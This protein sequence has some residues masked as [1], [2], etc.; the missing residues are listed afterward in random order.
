MK[1]EEVKKMSEKEME[2]K[3][4]ELQLELIKVKTSKT[5]GKSKQI[6]KMI[7]RIN[8]FKRSLQGGNSQK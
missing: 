3:L 7:A 1:F 4:E 2:K 5:G 6:R 8:T